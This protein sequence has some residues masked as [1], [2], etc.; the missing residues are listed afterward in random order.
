MF[1]KIKSFFAEARQEF[2]RINWPTL[3][4]TRRLTLIVIG[5]SLA[6]AI[7]LGFLDF[8]FTRLLNTFFVT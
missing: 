5:L 1:Q 6:I 3:A 7:F 8:I 4:E 2:K